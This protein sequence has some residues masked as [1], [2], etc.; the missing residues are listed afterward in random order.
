MKA[1]EKKTVDLTVMGVLVAVIFLLT[2]MP[3]K[4]GPIE[5]TLRMIPVVLGGILLGPLQGAILGG[6][7]GLT[8]FFECFG[9]LGMPLSAFGSFMVGLD[10][11]LTAVM[12]FVPRIIMG[13]CAALIFKAF[14]EKNVAA[15][16][17]ANISGALLNTV[18]FTGL[19]LLLFWSNPAFIAK[20][21]E[22]GL[23]TSNLG[24]FVVA[25]V[26]LNGLIEALV[27]VF[28]GTAISKGVSKAVKVGEQ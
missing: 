13:F 25:F 3:L 8:S 17:V 16:A 5:M 20:M 15:H 6:F 24:L 21:Q 19:L 26:G 12:C 23:D 11:A 4:V 18:L 7:F 27:C 1:R 14:K 2:Y 28:I 22:W 10:P 9:L